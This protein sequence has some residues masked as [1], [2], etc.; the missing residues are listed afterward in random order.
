MNPDRQQAIEYLRAP[1][2]GLWGWA[3]NG[4]ALVWRDGSTIAFREEIA[5]VLEWLAPNGLP[6]FG[7]IVFLLAACRGKVPQI[8]EIVAEPVA[9]LPAAARG[10]AALLLATRQQLKAQLSAALDQL[11][12]VSRLPSELNTGLK[13]RCVLAEAVFEP[14]RAER[15]VEARTILRGLREPIGDTELLDPERTGVGGGYI[16][17]IHIVAE[18]LKP[19]TPESLALR[20]RTGLDS[21]PKE[22]DIQLPTAERAR[23]LIEELSRDRECGAVARA[24][25]ELIAAVRLPRRLGEREQ[26]A[27]GGVADITNRGPLDRLLLSELA[28]D[29]LTLSVRV[30]LNEALY[31]RREPPMREPPGTLALLLDSGLRLWGV[32]RVLATAVALALIARDKQHCEVRVWRAHG[33]RLLP[34]DLLSRIGLTQHLGALETAAHPGEAMAAFAEAISPGAQNQSVLITHRD[35]LNDPEFRRALADNPAAPGFVAVVDREGR[36]ELHALPLARRP[37]LCEAD[38]DLRSVLDERAGVSPIKPE[39]DPHLPAIFQMSPY[40]FLL[41]L[42]GRVDFWIKADDGLTYAVLNDR[43]LVQFRD[44]RT[45][46]RIV[47][48]D[49]P[50]GKTVWMG[51]VEDVV[52]LVKAGASQRPPWL[53]SVPLPDGQVRVTELASG[54]DLHAVHCCGEVILAIRR[55]DVRAYS[56]SDGRQLGRA[57]NPHSWVHGRLFLGHSHFYFAAWDGENVKFEPVT[58]T[59]TFLMSSVSLMFDREGMQGPW[60]LFRSGE[61]VS[62]E[63]GQKIRLPNPSNV[64]LDYGAAQVSRDGHVLFVP[65][66][67]KGGDNKPVGC[68]LRLQDKPTIEEIRNASYRLD[69]APPL[70]TWNVYRL[71]ESI[72]RLKDGLAIC[73]RRNRWRKISLNAGNRLCISDLPL[74]EKANLLNLVSFTQQEKPTGCGCSLQSVHWPSGSQAVLD[75]RGLLHL[76]SHDPTVPE[77]SLVLADAEIACWT[78]DGH[79]CGPP[80]FFEGAYTTEPVLVFARIMQFLDRL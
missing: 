2:G 79:V 64:L 80:F 21:L 30:A 51:C 6:T 13:A 14:A 75:S 33:K 12:K 16:R 61:V 32:P 62:T 37:P 23:R 19:H 42:A 3:D 65:S 34:V 48:S 39:V 25:R 43:R 44:H 40:P 52:H 29:D 55:H 67:K 20:L 24:A 46:A 27:L 8:A 18:G 70:P 26:L 76:K 58:M 5:Q 69:P 68:L 59:G 78:S 47:A 35:A 63:T 7:S 4:A 57:L 54:S 56:L 38:L 53:L 31:L 1:A 15:H 49:L 41:P 72:A 9:L 36:F 11:A 71:V 45:G 77:I 66:R 60:L 74:H 73:G 17:Q 22:T 50:A 10:N 28:H